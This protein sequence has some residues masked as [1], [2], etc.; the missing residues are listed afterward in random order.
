MSVVCAVK[1]EVQPQTDGWWMEGRRT[2]K[3]TPPTLP[4]RPSG[5]R[6]GDDDNE[7]EGM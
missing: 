7:M 5:A 6:G 3:K 4:G 2:E 1:V